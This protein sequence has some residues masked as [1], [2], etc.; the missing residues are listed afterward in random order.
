MWGVSAEKHEARHDVT[1]I[2]QQVPGCNRIDHP[3]QLRAAAQHDLIGPLRLGAGLVVGKANRNCGCVEIETVDAAANVDARPRDQNFDLW[4]PRQIGVDRAPGIK[5]EPDLRPASRSRL[6]R[7]IE[8]QSLQG[9]HAHRVLHTALARAARLET[10]GRNVASV[11]KPPKIEAEEIEILAA[12]QIRDVLAKLQGHALFPIVALALGTGMRRGEIC[13]L[14]WGDVDLDGACL[15]VSRSMEETADGLKPKSPKTRN[16]RRTISLPGSVVETLR[17]HRVQQLGR[18]LTLGL[19]RLGAADLVF[20]MPDG[21]PRSPDNLSRDWRR[22]VQALD[23]PRVM[24]HALRHS[25]ASALIAAGL[26]VLTISRRLGHGSA[27][28]TLN[29]Y[30][31]L[32]AD[33]ADAAAQAMDAAMGA[34]A[35]AKA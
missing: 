5:T 21:A 7:F 34:G 2:W 4:L 10:I 32:F 1:Q 35:G 25:H 17:A 22:A 26:D 14:Q 29:T 16:G 6:K 18:R 13:A 23:L 27:A 33:K 24:F 11:V 15:R 19:G 28:F 12:D 30:T 31:H 20:T 8:R 3:L 9:G